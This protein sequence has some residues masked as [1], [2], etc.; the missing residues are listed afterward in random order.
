MRPLHRLFGPDWRHALPS[1]CRVCHAWPALTLCARCVTRF[2]PHTTR[3]QRCALPVTGGAPVC[4]ACLRAPPPV[5][6]CLAALPYAW[7]WTEVIAQFKFHAEPGLASPLGHLLQAASGVVAALASADLVLP[8]PLSDERLAERGYN[9]A[10]LLARHLAAPPGS[11]RLDLLLRTRH[12]PPQHGLPRA[13][14][15]RNVR[16]AYA[17]EPR[18]AAELADRR[19][20][21]VD[22]VMTTGAS[23]FEAAHSVRAA[24]ARYVT[25]VTLARTA[26]H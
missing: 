7:P 11:L 19:V 18:R 9:P 20:V 15:L 23:L 22:D 1:Q 25:A 2:A 5:D 16:G 6:S 12:T 24:G 10:Q 3:C 17:V 26:E 14:R 13:Q 4:G 8:L 21:L